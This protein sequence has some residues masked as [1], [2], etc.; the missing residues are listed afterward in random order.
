MSMDR[1]PTRDRRPLVI[2]LLLALGFAAGIGWLVVKVR[3]F[4]GLLQ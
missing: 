3:Q 4:S 2:I 1:E